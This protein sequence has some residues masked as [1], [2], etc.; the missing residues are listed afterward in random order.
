MDLIET[1]TCKRQY[2][3]YYRYDA[4]AYAV[5]HLSRVET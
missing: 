2:D 3:E 4:N 1:Q 5:P